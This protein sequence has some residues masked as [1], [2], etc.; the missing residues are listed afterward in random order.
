MNGE[1]RFT[2]EDGDAI[3]LRGS[4]MLRAMDK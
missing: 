1:T 3:V 4:K 2:E